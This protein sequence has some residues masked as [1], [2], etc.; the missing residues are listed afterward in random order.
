MLK[1]LLISRS[2]RLWVPHAYPAQLAPLSECEPTIKRLA[3]A[4][5]QAFDRLGHRHH[6]L[7]VVAAILTATY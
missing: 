5:T 6:L 7:I 2:E 4:V 1:F 3:D